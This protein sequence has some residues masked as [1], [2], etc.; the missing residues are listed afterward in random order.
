MKLGCLISVEVGALTPSWTVHASWNIPVMPPRSPGAWGC[1]SARR[2]EWPSAGGGESCH[3]HDVA[4][5][6]ESPHAVAVAP[7]KQLVGQPGGDARD[8]T[9]HFGYR[10]RCLPSPLAEI[11]AVESGE[12]SHRVDSAR[13]RGGSG[14]EGGKGGGGGIYMQQRSQL[15]VCSSIKEKKEWLSCKCQWYPIKW[16]FDLCIRKRVLMPPT[17]PHSAKFKVGNSNIKR[18][19]WTKNSIKVGFLLLARTHRKETAGINLLNN[20]SN[21]G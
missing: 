16:H 17:L 1:R 9:K 15:E 20:K 8:Q 7:Q 4:T 14:N 12:M 18:L 21:V 3:I 10:D 11:K 6:S 13:G 19:K 5:P 2:L